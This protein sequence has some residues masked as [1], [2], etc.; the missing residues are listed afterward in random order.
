MQELG[1]E[2]RDGIPA[3]ARRFIG[4][5]A[6]TGRGTCGL[7]ACDMDHKSGSLPFRTALQ[8]ANIMAGDERRH[9]PPGDVGLV[10]LSD[11]VLYSWRLDVPSGANPL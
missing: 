10:T 1:G 2:N 7:L 8:P 6:R 5:E 11:G 4:A 9:V 3:W